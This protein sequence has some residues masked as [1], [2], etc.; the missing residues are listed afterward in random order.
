MKEVKTGREWREDEWWGCELTILW[1]RTIFNNLEII[2]TV[3]QNKT[4]DKWVRLLDRNGDTVRWIDSRWGQHVLEWRSCTG[5]QGG[6]MTRWRLRESTEC[7]RRKISLYV[8]LC[9]ILYWPFFPYSHICVLEIWIYCLMRTW[10][11][12]NNLVL[13]SVHFL[14]LSEHLH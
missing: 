9:F 1:T 10:F 7:V 4:S 14:G 6:S 12:A 13:K 11:L 8:G 5:R 3:S 2:W